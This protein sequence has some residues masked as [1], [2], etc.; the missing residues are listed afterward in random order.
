MYTYSLRI[1]GVHIRILASRAITLSENFYPFLVDES[2]MPDISVEVVFGN[3]LSKGE[4]RSGLYRITQNTGGDDIIRLESEG[5]KSYQLIIP[6]R[7]ADSVC[8]NANW[9]LYLPLERLLLPFHRVILHAS[10][11][12][13]QGNA[14]VFTAPS[15]MG[16]S[17]QADIWSREFGAEIIN[18]DKVI[19]SLEEGG[20]TAHGGPAA[21]SSGI[22]K[23]ICAPVAAIMLLEKAEKNRI[24]YEN[25]TTDFFALYSESVKSTADPE[26][27]RALLPEIEKIVKNVPVARLFCRPDRGAAEC[28]LNWTEARKKQS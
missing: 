6:E 18:G 13:Y 7:L 16:K 28:V 14:Y 27:N 10:A 9:L 21:G 8:K 19:L 17:T 24:E 3:T 20:V 11:V 5:R 25:E 22:H 2:E 4:E 23:N 15:G 1:A 26:F 12:I